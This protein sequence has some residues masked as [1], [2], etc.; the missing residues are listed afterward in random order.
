LEAWYPL[1]Y[2]LQKPSR[3][4]PHNIINL[5]FNNSISIKT[6]SNYDIYRNF[7]LNHQVKKRKKMRKKFEILSILLFFVLNCLYS[8][9]AIK[10]FELIIKRGEFKKAQAKIKEEFCKNDKLTVLQKKELEFEIE[11][12]DRIRLDFKKEEKDILKYIKNYIPSVTKKDLIK[13]EKERSLE[14][15]VIDGK[16]KYFNNAAPNLFR[17]NKECRKIKR[18][19]DSKKNSKKEEFDLVKLLK[20]IIDE[21]KAKNSSKVKP[22]R[23]QID[24]SISVDSDAVPDGEIIRCWLPY[25]REVD[26]KQDGIQI[27]S[28]SPQKYIL[29]DNNT[30]LQRTIYFEQTAQKGKKTVFNISYQYNCYAFY[31]PIDPEKVKSYDQNSEEYK[32]YTSERAPHILFTKEIRELSKKIIGA[33]TNTYLKAKKIFEWIDENIPWASAREYSTIKNIPMYAFENKHGDCGIQT[34]LFMTLA[35]LSG[36]PTKWQS[37]WEPTTMHDWCYMKIEPFGWVPVD[38]SYG[39]QKSDDNSIKYFYLGNFEN[40]RLVINDD[41]SRP[42]YPAK[43]HPRSETIDFQRGEVEWYGGNLYFDKWDYSYNI[44][45][46]K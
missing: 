40:R 12:L 39:I 35:R 7:S 31:N 24:Y 32:T 11:R 17:I 36:I 44:K 16:K 38:Q 43:I 30:N 25:P 29:A 33:E 8:Q 3:S 19:A 5:D 23:Y 15:M 13:W 26:G 42:L 2:L 14:C 18:E 9:D 22:I 4:E 1:E 20:D 27:L 41:Y 46:V 28:T 6:F 37:G 34:L 21:S 45:E 10:K